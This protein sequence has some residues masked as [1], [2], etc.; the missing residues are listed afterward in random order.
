MNK[1][2]LVV[3][4]SLLII[5][6]G[7]VILLIPKGSKEDIRETESAKE[8]TEEDYK[9]NPK[10]ILEEVIVSDGKHLKLLEVENVWDYRYWEGDC[11]VR[12]A[13]ELNEQGYN[14]IINQLDNELNIPRLEESEYKDKSIEGFLIF[15]DGSRY[16]AEAISETTP[17]QLL[18]L[19]DSEV[20]YLLK[21]PDCKYQTKGLGEMVMG[22]FMCKK[23]D[24]NYMVFYNRYEKDWY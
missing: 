6:V 12:G 3:I 22:I 10:Y 7:L 15:A 8:I 4:I 2:R 21:V 11:Y 14:D 18:V 17:S 1:K 24:K 23:Y 16:K 5:I 9:T 13:L 20:S 19:E